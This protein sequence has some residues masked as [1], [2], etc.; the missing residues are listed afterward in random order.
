[1]TRLVRDRAQLHQVVLLEKCNW[2]EESNER[3]ITVRSSPRPASSQRAIRVRRRRPAKNLKETP[4]GGGC[5]THIYAFD[6]DSNRT[7][8]TSRAPEPDG[9]CKASGGQLQTYSYDAGDRLTDA[10]ITYDSFG[11][12]TSLPGKYAGGS[13]LA[14]TFYANKWSQAR[15]RAASLTTTNLMPWAESAERPKSGRRINRSLS[16]RD[17]FRLSRP[18][19]NLRLPGRATSRGSGQPRG[20]PSELWL[21]MLQLTNLHGD[22]VATAPDNAD[23]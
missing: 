13:A 19:L 14:T 7:S 5:T 4:T 6:A 15:P 10:E 23:C 16:L 18:G 21:I 1:M 17:G 2:I 8:L 9:S 20:D 3:S 12:I 11:R 22:V